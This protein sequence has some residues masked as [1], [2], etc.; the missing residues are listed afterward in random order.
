M[1]QKRRNQERLQGS[2]TGSELVFIPLRCQMTSISLEWET[3][4]H[5]PFIDT[6]I[7][8]TNSGLWSCPTMPVS[9]TVQLSSMSSAI[10]IPMLVFPQRSNTLV[11]KAFFFL[12]WPFPFSVAKSSLVHWTDPFSYWRRGMC[13]SINKCPSYSLIFRYLVPSWCSLVKL[14][15][16]G[17]AG[18][19]LSLRVGFQ[20]SRIQTIPSLICCFLFI[21]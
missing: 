13:G 19:S 11:C 12:E 15:R 17:F 10:L 4:P 6:V 14:R 2:L 7:L 1:C 9:F 5:L 3:G 8:I 16:C 21:A 18:G 20:S